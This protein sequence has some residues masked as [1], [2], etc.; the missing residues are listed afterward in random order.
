MPN[1]NFNE[2][3]ISAP[4]EKV[5]EYL[6]EENGKI[7]FNMHKIFPEKFPEDDASGF[8]NWDYDWMNEHTSCKWHPEIDTVGSADLEGY[9]WISYDSAWC[10]NEGTLL[11]LSKLTWWEITN[12][13][14]EP[15]CSFA[16]TYICKNWKVILDE[17]RDCLWQCGYCEERF[18]YD[19]LIDNNRFSYLCKSCNWNTQIKIQCFK[20]RVDFMRSEMDEQMYYCLEC[21]KKH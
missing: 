15:W 11:Q 12:E 5:K 17:V 7:Y 20:C 16:G 3:E 10:P 4:L 14:E 8:K 9:A 1:W 21:N 18:E 2:V 13:Y 6:V 19:I